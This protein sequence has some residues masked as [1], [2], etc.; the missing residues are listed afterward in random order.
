MSQPLFTV[1][2]LGL[3]ELVEMFVYYD[4]PQVFVCR[5]RAGQCYLAHLVD[6]TAHRTRWFFVPVSA[7][8][9]DQIRQG[10][11]TLRESVEVPEEGWLWDIEVGS[12]PSCGRAHQRLAETLS[13]RELPGS[14]LRIAPVTTTRKE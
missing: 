7:E 1:P 2:V 4:V 8:R 14:S 12:D 6:D 3:L 13:D 11:V 5:D 10:T 9:L